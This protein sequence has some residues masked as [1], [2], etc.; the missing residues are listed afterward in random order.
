MRWLVSCSSFALA[1]ERDVPIGTRPGA[2]DG[3]GQ[4][5]DGAVAPGDGAADADATSNDAAD[6][7][8]G[9]DGSLADGS[10]GGLDAGGVDGAPLGDGAVVGPFLDQLARPLT[11]ASG[12]GRA[13]PAAPPIASSWPGPISAPGGRYL[14][15][16]LRPSGGGARFGA[17]AHADAGFLG[18]ARDRRRSFGLWPGVAGATAD[19]VRRPERWHLGHGRA[20]GNRRSGRERSPDRL[21]RQRLGRHLADRTQ[22]QQ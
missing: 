10:D 8:A 2:R 1:C 11:T 20:A 7:D 22:Q 14:R 3:G 21:E 17:A 6:L 13:Q 9:L 12:G 19:D 4:S 5:A 16:Q 18:H 15:A